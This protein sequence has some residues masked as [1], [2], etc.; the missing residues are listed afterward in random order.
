MLVYRSTIAVA[1]LAGATLVGC[2]D[3]DQPTD[4]RKD[5][6]PNITVVTVLSD[7]E[8]SVDP[9]PV[10]LGRILETATFCRLDDEKRP[11]LVGLPDIRVIQVCPENLKDG[12]PDSGAAEAAPPSWFVRVVFDKLLDASIEDLVPQLDSMGKPTGITL[13]TLKNTQPV[14][15]KCNGTDV[16]YD[17]YY[18]PNGNRS[19]WPLGPALFIQPLSTISVPTA[20]SCTVS[21][22]DNVHNKVGQSVPTNQRDYNFKLAGMTLRFSSPDPS[23]SDKLDGSIPVDPT[24]PVD[25]YWTAAL[26]TP[27]AVADIQI[28][29]GP[30]LNVTAANPDGDP[31]P[32]VC[33]G[34]GG[35]PVAANQINSTVRGTT[36]TTTQ[37]VNRIATGGSTPPAAGD[38]RWDPTTT[39]LVKFGAN[40]KVVPV[41][42]IT[43]GGPSGALPADYALCFHTTAGQ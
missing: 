31:D 35:T 42:G 1:M 27:V 6:P 20:A 12:A 5:G 30:N 8:T 22:K 17:G 7:L 4:L 40:A 26:L 43:A 39:Y 13:G 19:S 9:S 15:L 16:P 25:F 29:S 10:G 41:Q 32:A 23:D 24:S 11:F 21:V 28:T 18:V 38:P 33:A 14:T 37:L 2:A 36:A 3:P 34:T